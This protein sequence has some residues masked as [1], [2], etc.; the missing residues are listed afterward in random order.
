MTTKSATSQVKGGSWRRSL[1]RWSIWAGRAAARRSSR[2]RSHDTTAGSSAIFSLSASNRRRA[3]RRTTIPTASG[4]D[5]LVW[6]RRFKGAFLGATSGLS[7]ATVRYF[8]NRPEPAKISR[9]SIFT[10]LA[11]GGRRITP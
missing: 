1:F 9:N 6:S 2:R 10:D 3:P 7:A 8:A 11:A 5:V 4:E